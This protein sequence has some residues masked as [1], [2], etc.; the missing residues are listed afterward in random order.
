M[1]DRKFRESFLQMFKEWKKEYTESWNI[2]VD[3]VPVLGENWL[4]EYEH[5]QEKYV[6]RIRV[7]EKLSR[8]K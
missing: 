7:E 6:I 1:L 8:E 2:D 4:Q 5:K 3:F